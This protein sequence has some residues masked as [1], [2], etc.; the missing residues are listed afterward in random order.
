M[1]PQNQK[2][3]EQFLESYWHEHLEE[4]SSVSETVK[5]KEI[6]R[7]VV[8][9]LPRLV[10][11]AAVLA[12]IIAGA[13]Y[14]MSDKTGPQKS[15]QTIAKTIVKQE[16]VDEHVA[17]NTLHAYPQKVNV[18]QSKTKQHEKKLSSVPALVKDSVVTADTVCRETKPKS[19][20]MT[21]MAKVMINEV[22]LNKLDSSEQLKVLN[23]M[24][25]RVNI[26]NASFNEIAAILQN[27]YGIVIELCATSQPDV[28]GKYT[29]HF[30]QVSFPELIDDMSKQM[31]FS[32]TITDKKTVKV[33]FN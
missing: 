9:Y 12:F 8:R 7:G 24:A 11:A 3:F 22:A 32:Y 16:P 1:E 17:S 19:M 25:L 13:Y 23:Q 20:K 5:P 27:K 4:Q 31:L 29:A 18:H 6:S 14:F 28:A 33:C 21:P 26:N 2:V 15:N 10:A 30:Q